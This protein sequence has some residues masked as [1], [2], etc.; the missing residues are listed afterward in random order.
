MKYPC[1]DHV[2]NNRKVEVCESFFGCRHIY[3]CRTAN[4]GGWHCV[5]ND[6]QELLE[7][8]IMY[9]CKE[10]CKYWRD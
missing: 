6:T 1:Q 5:E 8:S 4:M 7:Q 10:H 3:I 2:L 9:S